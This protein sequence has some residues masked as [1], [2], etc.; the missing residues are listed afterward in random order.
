MN[1]FDT[2]IYTSKTGKVEMTYW[3]AKNFPEAAKFQAAFKQMQK[4]PMAAMARKMGKQPTDLPGVPVKVEVLEG[5]DGQK[6]VTTI[7]SVKEETLPDS[8]FT[9]PAGYQ[10]LPVPSFGT[11]GAGPRL[12]KHQSG[13][14]SEQ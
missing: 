11:G 5:K 9:V 8:E 1:G 10:A 2:E 12:P 7:V 4:S 6:I 13:P 14:D 3:I